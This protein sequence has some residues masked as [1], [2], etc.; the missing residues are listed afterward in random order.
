MGGDRSIPLSHLLPACNHAA[1]SLLHRGPMVAKLRA[2]IMIESEAYAAGGRGLNKILELDHQ[3]EAA[4]GSRYV[5]DGN[6]DLV[7]LERDEPTITFREM[8]GIFLELGLE[9]RF[10]GAIPLELRPRSKTQLLSA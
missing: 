9:P 10:V 7:D 4:P 1:N 6:R 2:V 3:L 5:V 8:R